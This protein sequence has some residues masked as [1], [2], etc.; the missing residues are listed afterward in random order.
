[1]NDASFVVPA[2]AGREHR[3]R[4]KAGLQT[5]ACSWEELLKTGSRSLLDRLPDEHEAAGEIGWTLRDPARNFLRREPS[6]A[7]DFLRLQYKRTFRCASIHPDELE[8]GLWA[9]IDFEKALQ[10]SGQLHAQFFPQFAHGAGVV[11]LADIQMSGSGRIPRPWEAVLSHGTLLQEQVSAGVEDEHVNGSVKE[12]L[13]MD[14]PPQPLTDHFIAF[15]YDVKSFFFHDAV[16]CPVAAGSAR[17]SRAVVGA[18]AGH[19]LPSEKAI[20]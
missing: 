2:L 3:S 14:F 9:T 18:L 5:N 17:A 12:P 15:V 6:A 1:M 19:T 16:V 11:A 10:R 7:F 4:L 20:I 8:A 13:L